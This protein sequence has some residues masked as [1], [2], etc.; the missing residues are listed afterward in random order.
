MHPDDAAS[1]GVKDGDRVNVKCTGPRG[2]GFFEVL[3]RVN[4]SY[5]LEM[6]V[7]LDEANAA[8]LRNGNFVEIIR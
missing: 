4:E 3:V 7:D 6:H 5:R 2:V 1:F 8:S